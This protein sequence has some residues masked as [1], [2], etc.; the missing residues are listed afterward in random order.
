MCFLSPFSFYIRE[1]T[2]LIK[3][4]YS[5]S[6]TTL[7]SLNI[8]PS[9]PIMYLDNGFGAYLIGNKS[10]I[11]EYYVLPLQRLREESDNESHVKALKKALA[12]DGRFLTVLDS[13][14]FKEGNNQKLKEKISREYQKKGELPMYTFSTNIFKR[15]TRE[16]IP[17][18]IDIYER[19]VP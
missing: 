16:G 12:Y 1:S 4:T 3:E 6:M 10:W 19:I 14:F 7:S 13:W 17:G 9:E 15:P 11:D 18:I 2:R 8:D 5:E